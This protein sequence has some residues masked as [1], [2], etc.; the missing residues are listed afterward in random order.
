M[1]YECFYDLPAEIPEGTFPI[2]GTSLKYD[3]HQMKKWMA[4]R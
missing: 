4:N 1:S 2:P 3:D